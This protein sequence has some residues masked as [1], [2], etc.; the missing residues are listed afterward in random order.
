M[1]TTSQPRG[2][3]DKVVWSSVRSK[4][5]LTYGLDGSS[6]SRKRHRPETDSNEKKAVIDGVGVKNTAEPP[7]AT[8]IESMS[9]FRLRY[10]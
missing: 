6:D 5:Q 3:Y 1:N 8:I 10:A 4:Q 9:K 7:N 2:T